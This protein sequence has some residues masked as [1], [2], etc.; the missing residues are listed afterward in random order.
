MKREQK[1]LKP[2]DI[3]LEARGKNVPNVEKVEP[4]NRKVDKGLALGHGEESSSESKLESGS[5]CP[6]SLQ[7]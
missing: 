4:S 7:S 3:F 6:G 2:G 1:Y 5:R